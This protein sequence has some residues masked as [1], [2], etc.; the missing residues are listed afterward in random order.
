MAIMIIPPVLV[1]HTPTCVCACVCTACLRSLVVAS[2]AMVALSSAQT[3]HAAGGA[4]GL[5]W[6]AGQQE[7]KGS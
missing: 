4:P 2:H 5:L 3:R 6:K 1:I 7:R